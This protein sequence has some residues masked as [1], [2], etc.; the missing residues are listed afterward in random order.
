MA[1]ANPLWGAPFAAGDWRFDLAL[2][3]D[4]GAERADWHGLGPDLLVQGPD[5]IVRPH[6]LVCLAH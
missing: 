5:A 1:A 2:R 6:S 3:L 4:V